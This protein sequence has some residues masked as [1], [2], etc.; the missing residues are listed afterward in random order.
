MLLRFGRQIADDSL[1]RFI[2]DVVVSHK[3][4]L[5]TNRAFSSGV[6]SKRAG[7]VRPGRDW[8]H[9]LSEILFVLDLV[10]NL[11]DFLLELLG[12][13]LGELP[14]RLLVLLPQRCRGCGGCDRRWPV[15]RS[16]LCS[17]LVRRVSHWP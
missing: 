11:E 7:G 17:P 9:G 12:I 10:V 8:P 16:R 4:Q 6:A 3:A 5:A 13:G 15:P 14:G 1:P 2:V